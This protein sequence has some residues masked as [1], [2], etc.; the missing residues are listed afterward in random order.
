MEAGG[1]ESH[2]RENQILS[3][4]GQSLS[5]DGQILSQPAVIEKDT[6]SVNIEDGTKSNL[7]ETSSGHPKTTIGTQQE[8]NRNIT[9]LPENHDLKKINETW[10][11]LPEAMKMGIMAMIEAAVKKK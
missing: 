7:G 5:S 10:K 3:S 4:K 11:D 6:S 2:S 8:H 1:V 9:E